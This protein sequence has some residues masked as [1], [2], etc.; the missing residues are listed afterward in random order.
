MSE[1]KVL[2]SIW[3]SSGNS[4]WFSSGNLNIVGIVIGEREGERK[5]YIKNVKGRNKEA[6]IDDI[7]TRGAPF[8][9]DAAYELFKYLKPDQYQ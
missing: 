5:A 2:D 7:A 1:F 8:P 6:D 9:L 3:F 4:N